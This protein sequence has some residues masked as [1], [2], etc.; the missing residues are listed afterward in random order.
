MVRIL[1]F[2]LFVCG[3]S[4][5]QEFKHEEIYTQDTVY[6]DGKREIFE[7]NYAMVDDIKRYIKNYPDYD[8]LAY[9]DFASVFAM[10]SINE[11]RRS[12]GL[13]PIVFDPHT[14]W[15]LIEECLYDYVKE[16]K[17]PVLVK[18][19][20]EDV[21]NC[22]GCYQELVGEIFLHKDIMRALNSSSLDSFNVA[23]FYAE[24]GNYIF[25]IETYRSI[26]YVKTYIK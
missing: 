12:K 10:D 8:S 14:K 18:R 3:I 21:C 5:G 4:Y 1:V 26:F 9:L 16:V 19:V 15:R 7:A 13:E 20:Y 22:L 2:L 11:Y 25:C 24:K 17:K 6:I 23:I